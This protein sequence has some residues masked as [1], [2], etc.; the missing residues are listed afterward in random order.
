MKEG[1]HVFALDQ[2]KVRHWGPLFLNAMDITRTHC[3]HSR[4]NSLTQ[5][6]LGWGSQVC[7]QFGAV[8]TLHQ[9]KRNGAPRDSF[10][11]KERDMVSTIASTAKKWRLPSKHNQAYSIPQKKI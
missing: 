4:Y 11:T 5:T 10:S 2:K 6:C 3:Y 1:R 8:Y 7:W 9:K